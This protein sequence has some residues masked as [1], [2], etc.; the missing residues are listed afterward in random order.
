MNLQQA[1]TEASRCLLCHDAPCSSACP[2]G[3]DPGTFI[4]QI[5]FYNFKGAA[6][7]IIGNNPLGAVC[8]EVCPT[9]DSCV[10]ACLRTELDQPIDIGALQAF[11]TAYG[12]QHGL[13]VMH[14]G[15]AKDQ[16]V[17]V[18]G[19]GPAGLAAAAVLA[20]RGYGVTVFEARAQVGGMLRYGVPTSRLSESFLEADLQDILRLDVEFKT[21]QRIDADDGAKALL[22]QGFA[23]VFVAPGLW[24][25]NSLPIPGADLD[26]VSTALAFLDDARHKPDQVRSQVQDKTVCVIGGGSVAMDVCTSAAAL[27]AQRIYVVALEDMGDLPAQDEEVQECMGLG[28]RFRTQC[29]INSIVG[30]GKVNAVK[31]QEI[32]WIE[33]GK[34]IPSN[35]RPIE[36]SDFS[37]PVDVVV[38]AIGQGADPCLG[39]ILKGAERAGHFLKADEQT[40][41]ISLKGLFAGGDIV[42]GPATV[43]EAV[44]DGKRAAQAIDNMLSGSQE[45]AQ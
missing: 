40:L 41:A 3:T 22:D 16:R 14:K 32:A 7:T 38:Q 34:L 17:A 26:G 11:A 21:D 15:E 12:R 10:G 18:V 30:D 20:Q 4:R 39:Q 9:A 6:R 5:R 1:I 27:G 35:A 24:K 31:G 25:G 37:L 44:A 42:R 36:H 23:A 45:V 19:G 13:Q 43:V 29:Q 2:A 28:V 8:A 33:P